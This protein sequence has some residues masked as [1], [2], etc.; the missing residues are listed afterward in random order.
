MTNWLATL[1]LCSTTSVLS[2]DGEA[3]VRRAEEQLYRWP[4]AHGRIAFEVRTDVLA[5]G[6]AAMERDLA[7]NPD[8]EGSRVV[9]ALKAARIRGS[10][11]TADGNVSVDVAIDCETLDRR[12]QVMLA[13]VKSIVNAQVHTA[14]DGLPL[15]GAS[16]VPAGA[17]VGDARE[18]GE[19]VR[20]ELVRGR[21]MEPGEL[22]LD[23]RSALPL[24]LAL[25]SLTMRYE[26]VALSR[27]TYVPGTV[28]VEPKSGAPSSARYTWQSVAE[29]VFPDDVAITSGKQSSRLS[30]HELRFEPAQ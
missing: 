14:L 30:F 12:A 8:A 10:L 11:D 16:L 15:R 6:I 13:Q 7:R 27:G 23:R 29:H 28:T 17:T 21:D 22:V 1:L 3:W 25:P 18:D 4:S 26:F 9:A 20:I 5:P 24:A 19:S 2:Q